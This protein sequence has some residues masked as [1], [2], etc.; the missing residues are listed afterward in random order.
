MSKNGICFFAYNTM[1]IDYIKFSILSALYAKKHM[2]NNQ[3]CLI[4]KQGDFDYAKD[5][6]GEELINRAFDHVVFTEDKFRENERTHYDSPWTKF[7]SQFNNSNKHKVF[8]YSPFD[9]TLMLDIDYL[10]QNNNL[11]YVFET[12]NHVTMYNDAVGVD[13]L[14]MRILEKYLNPVGVPMWWSTVVYFD[15][16]EFSKLFF[17]LWGH[18]VDNYDFYKFLYKLP[19]TVMRTD[20]CASIAAHI[21]NGMMEGDIITTF[22]DQ[23]LVNMDQK[24]ELE[25]VINA[26]DFVFLANNREENWKDIVSRIQNTNVHLMN[27]RSVDR[28]YDALMEAING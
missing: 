13:S 4:T 16:S 23:Y 22:K 7:K 3:T 21:L 26:K 11:D 6:H 19:G 15:K 10:V 9:R 1:E 20:F 24:D 17:D 25:K 18:V 28:N 8:E 2:K 12:D 5:T 27:K 14:E